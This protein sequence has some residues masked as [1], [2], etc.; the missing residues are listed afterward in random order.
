MAWL[1]DWVGMVP[2]IDFRMLT[3]ASQAMA[4]YR[5][6]R[7]LGEKGGQGRMT[8]EDWETVTRVLSVVEGWESAS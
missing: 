1:L 2:G 3:R 7:K 8:P 4:I 5:V 6:F